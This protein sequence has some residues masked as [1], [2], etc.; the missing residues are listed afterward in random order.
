MFQN[1]FFSWEVDNPVLRVLTGVTNRLSCQL[2]SS[3]AFSN[4]VIT[5]SKPTTD[6]KDTRQTVFD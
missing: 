6:F 1:G 4:S 3:T 2:S 5:H